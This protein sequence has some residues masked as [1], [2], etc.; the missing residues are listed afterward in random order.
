MVVSRLQQRRFLDQV[1]T[2]FHESCDEGEVE[3][4]E[5]LLTQ[6]DQIIQEPLRL[7]MGVDRRRPEHL[8]A[9]AER[10]INLLLWRTGNINH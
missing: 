5:I 2:A 1:C 7:P 10:L 3:I 4:A 6:M 9:A 8:T